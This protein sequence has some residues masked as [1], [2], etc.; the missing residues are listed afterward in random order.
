MIGVMVP[1]V[2]AETIYPTNTHRVD[3]P[4]SYCAVKPS[5]TSYLPRF[6]IF[7]W[8]AEVEEAVDDW[9]TKL[10]NGVA[11]EF[12][13]LWNLSYLGSDTEPLPNCDYPI[14]LKSTYT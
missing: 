4:P 10:Q 8:E 1:S 11:S 2:F 7:A 13:Y 14:Y 6:S 5:D 12:K 9:R 3:T